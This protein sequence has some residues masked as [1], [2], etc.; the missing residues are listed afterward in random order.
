MIFDLNMW[1]NQIFYYPEAYGQYTGEFN[2]ISSGV[3]WDLYFNQLLVLAMDYRVYTVTNETILQSSDPVLWSYASRSQVF[4]R[5]Y[6]ALKIRS[7]K[8]SMK[9]LKNVQKELKS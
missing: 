6:Q 3:L 2:F 4:P 5:F 7:E 1:K 8:L 9:V